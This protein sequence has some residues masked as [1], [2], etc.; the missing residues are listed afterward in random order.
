MKKD[1]LVTDQVSGLIELIP[2]LRNERTNLVLGPYREAIMG[3]RS[4]GKTYQ[5]IAD[6]L[7][8]YGI[9]LSMQTIRRYIQRNGE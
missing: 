8:E 4:E 5:V 3:L 1:M 9:T 6:A 2:I 7:K